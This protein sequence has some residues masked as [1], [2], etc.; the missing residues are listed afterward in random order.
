MMIEKGVPITDGRGV[1]KSAGRPPKYP[2]AEMEV[3]DSFKADVPPDVLRASASGYAR[4]NGGKFIVRVD[5]DGSR[6]WRVE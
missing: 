5:G 2:W 1:G 3:G 4:R 6:A